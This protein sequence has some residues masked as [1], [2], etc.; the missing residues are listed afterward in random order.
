MNET[1]GEKREK[2]FPVFLFLCRKKILHSSFSE[3]IARSLSPSLLLS[4]SSHGACPSSSSGNG[5]RDIVPHG[6]RARAKMERGRSRALLQLSRQNV[7]ASSKRERES[8]HRFLIFLSLLFSPSSPQAVISKRIQNAKSEKFFGNIHKRGLV[9]N[10]TQVRERKRK[11]ERGREKS[12]AISEEAEFEKKKG[13]TRRASPL[14]SPRPSFLSLQQRQHLFSIEEKGHG[15]QRRAH[16]ARLLPLRRRRVGAAADHSHG[17]ERGT[18][19]I[20]SSSFG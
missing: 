6:R 4:L 12:G 13:K 20:F 17:H 7:D 14:L 15:L 16:H 2:R 1:W 10:T 11:R 9:Q 5:R 3:E 8:F 19:L 18:V